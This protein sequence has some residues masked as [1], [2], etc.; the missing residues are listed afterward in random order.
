MQSSN[1]KRTGKSY[2]RAGAALCAVLVLA[3]A[4]GGASA[5][6]AETVLH[7]FTG[8]I[9]DGGT[10]R[11]GLIADSKGNLYGTTVF[12]GG[13][14]NGA[15]FKLSPSGTE[16]VLHSFT[17]G[18]D[19]LFPIGGLI[20][21]GNGNLFGTTIEGGA[22]GAGVVFKL[23]PGGTETVLHAFAGGSDGANPVAGLIADSSG[24]LYGTALNGG[25]S[26]CN[27]GSRCGVVF[28][29]SPS[30]T[31][32]VLY[33]FTGGSDGANPRAGLIADS[34]GNFYG[35]TEGSGAFKFGTVFKLSPSGTETVLY[36]FKGGSDGRFPEAG[37]I[38]DSSGNL[39]G[40]TV[41]GGGSEGCVFGCGVVFK[42]SPG[43]TYTVLYAFT[44]GSDGQFPSAG[45]IA[46][47]NGNL[48]GTAERGGA[49]GC[50]AFG[51]GVVF[52]LS[53]GGTETVLHSFTGDFTGSGGAIPRAGL[54][55]DSSG[56]LYGTTELGGAS[57][58]CD[59]LGCGVVFKLTGT[60]FV[61]PAAC[62][63]GDAA[64]VNKKFPPGQMTYD[65][66]SPTRI[67][68]SIML[69]SSS[70]I[71]SFTLPSVVSGGHSAPGGVFVKANPAKS[72]TFLLQANFVSPAFAC[73]IDPL[74]TTL[75]INTGHKIVQAFERIPGSEHFIE[76]DN[77]NPGLRWLR[78]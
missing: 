75:K 23:S 53:P 7:S 38:A 78:I 31:E 9:S 16:T 22:S 58:G 26:G 76:I 46:D 28:K 19:G 70:N 74:T 49:S 61:P 57:S 39:Y 24:N 73:S 68:K 47:S 18:S 71:G 37:L 69:T 20:A 65:V 8:G 56:N 13:S 34:S 5:A 44:G 40:T 64:L 21:D 63:S 3:A 33:S 32:T 41:E 15:V 50:D 55:A 59:S 43:G 52:K 42:L 67:L 12:G 51:C 29:L 17:G 45:L 1:T 6:P 72:A 48:Y 30:G 35:T 11:A 25:A 2:P 4:G 10:P 27:G 36:S 54:I 60:G 66:S 62:G 14:G 77:G